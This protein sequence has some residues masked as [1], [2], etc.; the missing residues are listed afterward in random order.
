MS[1]PSSG[2]ISLS[3]ILTEV[4][5]S[6]VTTGDFSDAVEDS[7]PAVDGGSLPADF[8]D[9]YGHTQSTTYG[10]IYAQAPTSSVAMYV[11]DTTNNVNL[12]SVAAGGSETLVYEPT[13]SSLTTKMTKTKTGTDF[14]SSDNVDGYLYR[15]VKGGSTW[16]QINSWSSYTGQTISMDF[17]NYDYKWEL[18]DV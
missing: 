18:G 17:G 9:F 7:D 3:A 1:L 13:V 5:R 15:R 10:K 12:G 6:G 11:R 4:E 2:D 16:S 14:T 8:T